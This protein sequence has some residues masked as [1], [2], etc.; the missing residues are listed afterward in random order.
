M[1][2]IRRI[3]QIL[4]PFDGRH[5]A[6][7]DPKVI[8]N[9]SYKSRYI[10]RSNPMSSIEWHVIHNRYK[11]VATECM[12]SKL[13]QSHRSRAEAL[14]VYCN[15]IISCNNFAWNSFSASNGLRIQRL[16]NTFAV[17][18]DLRDSNLFD[19]LF[20]QINYYN[21]RTLFANNLSNCFTPNTKVIY[22][23]H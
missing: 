16:G 12:A 14:E 3:S 23:G 15:C 19:Y 8:S 4:I 9:L 10:R 5:S 2:I 20:H 1:D 6:T 21:F 18:N 17:V 22:L 11:W 7:N 13:I